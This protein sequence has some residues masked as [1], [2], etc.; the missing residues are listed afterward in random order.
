MKKRGRTE[1]AR[2]GGGGSRDLTIGEEGGG[3][4]KEMCGEGGCKKEVEE[5]VAERERGGKREGELRKRWG[6]S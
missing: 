6:G 1:W 4:E 5:R 3:G 2:E